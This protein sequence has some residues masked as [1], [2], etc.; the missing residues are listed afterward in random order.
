MTQSQ[1]LTT[2][3]IQK[4]TGISKLQASRLFKKLEDPKKL[5]KELLGATF[6]AALLQSVDNVRGTQGTGEYE[7]Y[8]PAEYIDLARIVLGEID[9][10]PASHSQAQKNIKA[11]QYYTK[12]DNGLSHEWHGR[13]W[14]NPPYMQPLIAEFTKKMCDEYAAGRVTEGIMLTHN[15]TDTEWFQGAAKVADAL[16][17]TKGRIKFCEQDGS[18]VTAQPTQGQT[19]FYFGGAVSGFVKVFLAIGFCVVPVKKE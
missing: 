7:W 10:D 6:Q 19:F 16:C 9:L 14:L 3:E 15:Y 1:K 17:F 2:S 11:K 12:K 4:L 5:R 13:I 18:Q 8:T